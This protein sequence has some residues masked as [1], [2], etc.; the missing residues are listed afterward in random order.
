VTVIDPRHPL[1]NRTFPL[2]HIKNKQEKNPRCL[3]SLP[4]GVER[5][6]PIEVTNLAEIPPDV[7]LL[8]IDLHSLQT[9]THI[10]LRLEAQLEEEG[11]DGSHNKTVINGEG[12]RAATG[13]G[14]T[15]GSATGDGHAND[16]PDMP[17]NAQSMA[18]GGKG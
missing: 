7:F 13:L 2:L 11:R 16:D 18:G 5:W 10:F 15:R 9:L 1:F 8:P 6:L 4:E 14:D 3:I 17:G 12:A